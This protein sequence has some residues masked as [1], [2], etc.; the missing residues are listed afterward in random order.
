MGYC[1]KHNPC[2]DKRKRKIVTITISIAIIVTI[3]IGVALTIFKFAL[4]PTNLSFSLQDLT[5]YQF[6]QTS[7][8]TLTT[9]LHL[10][11][12]SHN[13]SS[14]FSLSYSGL[15][16]YASYHSQQITQYA[17]L[18]PAFL[19]HYEHCL[20]SP[21]LCGVEV[22]VTPY[23]A[24]VLS[25][26]QAAGYVVIDVKVEAALKWQF[27]VLFPGQSHMHVNCRAVLLCDGQNG[28][29]QGGG[30][31]LLQPVGCSASI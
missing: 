30:F 25:A 14:H 19:G 6:N 26:E 29:G 21:L 12:S 16:F 18:P 15:R 28:N 23:L 17:L 1:E 2:D 9:T 13:P 11:L 31:R 20:W 24:E 10:S 4:R 22:P 7:P 3:S 8:T 27:G 5:I